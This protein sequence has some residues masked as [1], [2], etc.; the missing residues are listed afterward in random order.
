MA[1]WV[2]LEHALQKGGIR[3]KPDIDEHTAGILNAG[4]SRAAFAQTDG[5]NGVLADDLLD[6]GFQRDFDLLGGRSLIEQRPLG[7]QVRATMKDGHA[8]GV[9]GEHYR[10]IE[11]GITP[12]HD[13]NFPARKESAIARGAM[14]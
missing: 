2:E 11:G 3:L 7:P 1:G 10:L 9:F 6:C 8:A 14:R 13:T 4:C 5:G 12:A